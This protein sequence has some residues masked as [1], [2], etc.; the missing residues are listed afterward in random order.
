[1]QLESTINID[2]LRDWPH[3]R[4]LSKRERPIV[5][6]HFKNEW[7]ALLL[8]R[9]FPL[10]AEGKPCEFFCEDSTD[11]FDPDTYSDKKLLS[12]SG[13]WDLTSPS[14]DE[15]KNQTKGIEK[16]NPQHD[17]IYAFYRMWHK[18]LKKEF[19]NNLVIQSPGYIYNLWDFANEIH[20]S[21]PIAPPTPPSPKNEFLGVITFVGVPLILLLSAIFHA[22]KPSNSANNAPTIVKPP[23][24]NQRSSR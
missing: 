1:M 21:L 14:S 9:G 17:A 6:K 18:V 5:A 7:R 16:S 19:P 13:I 24:V 8:T 10:F 20:V 4:P 15:E 22:N 12:D 23:E 3:W 11:L 2:I